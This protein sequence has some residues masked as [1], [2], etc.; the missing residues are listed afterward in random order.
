MHNTRM[1]QTGP[2]RAVTILM[3][4][5]AA[6][7]T[8]AET[9]ETR[10]AASAA[11][12]TS[13]SEDPVAE[14]SKAPSAPRPDLPAHM[15]ANFFLAIDAR[16]ALIDGKLEEARERARLLATQ[17][18]DEA[19]PPDLRPYL[20]RMKQHADGVVLAADPAEAGQ[21]LGMLAIA[22]GDCHWHAKQGPTAP[23]EPPLPF[24]EGPD[25]MGVR[26]F[27]HEVG[28]DQMWTGMITP[29]EEDY[30]SGTITL[31]RAPL[32]APEAGDGPLD[33]RLHAAVERIRDLAKQSR[34]ATTH[35]QRAKLYG[36]MITEC[37]SCHFTQPKAG[38]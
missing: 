33:P 34:A 1:G 7:C 19:F 35:Q 32:K 4:W 3:G 38:P 9:A 26:M 10:P 30:R 20:A 11:T 6:G 8:A 23:R 37:A 22:C 28:H 5:L 16:D 29:S 18:N 36:T 27:R 15:Q 31:T 14:A 17:T 25:D 12:E 21:E 13:G 24:Q 2:R